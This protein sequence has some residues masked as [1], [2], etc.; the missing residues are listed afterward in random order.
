M[1]ELDFVM[2]HCLAMMRL[3]S[4]LTAGLLSMILGRMMMMTMTLVIMSMNWHIFFESVYR[5]VV[6][7]AVLVVPTHSFQ[8]FLIS[9]SA[10]LL[11]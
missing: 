3:I 8:R 1:I 11:A 9:R 2:I 5:K 7:L 4:Q 10:K 6:A